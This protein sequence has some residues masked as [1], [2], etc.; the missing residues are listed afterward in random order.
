MPKA[1][2]RIG[3]IA[4]ARTGRV[5][6]IDIGSKSIRLVVYDRLIR[7]PLPVFNEKVMCGLGR[8]LAE[9]GRLDPGGRDAALENLVRFTTLLEG[10]NVDRVDVLATAAVRDAEDGASFVAEVA[11][12]TGLDIQVISGSE[13]ARL[14]GLG[15]L[16]GI[17]RA[18][19]VVGDLGGGSLE[20]VG[21]DQ[22]RISEQATLPLGPFRLMG[23]KGAPTKARPRVAEILAGEPW[24][25]A[26][27]GRPLYA[28]GG[29]WRALA[30]VHMAKRDHPIHVIQ[31]YTV[32]GDDMAELADLIAHQSSLERM[33]GVSKR[34]LEALPYAATVMV[35]LHDL[36]APEVVVFSAGGLR[37]GHLFDLLP[38]DQQADDPLL[39]ACRDIADRI[40][41]F[42]LGDVG[43]M[44][45]WI[46]P[47][48][49]D[50]PP[51][52]R[53]LRQ[54]AALL[55]DIGWAEH[56][57]YRAEHAFL[58]VL[59]LHAGGLSHVER[60]QLAIATYA[61]YGGSPG[62]GP[63]KPAIGLLSEEERTW[64]QRLGLALRLSHTLTGG[65]PEVLSRTTL[66]HDGNAIRLCLP[67]GAET[68][69][70]D[71]VRRRL[72]AVAKTMGAKAG[73]VVEHD[74]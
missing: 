34:R 36:L 53:R 42:G 3:P 4:R 35:A 10:M 62:N 48:F 49:A 70:G 67:S 14:S 24:L 17:P 9:T 30:K 7:A 71:V 21:V 56:P 52:F 58:R 57:D 5:G 61:R 38:A 41:R 28:V 50:E 25:E 2:F 26:Y 45:G 47:L 8:S 43:R 23:W 11:A 39:A 32:P 68:L 59:R 51:G 16:S 74:P 6:V 55:S 29:A 19:G 65:A 18:D 15:V 33:P 13:E 46:D 73:I 27:R 31:E 44:A 66:E 54:A 72:D 22:G 60:A 12:R 64:A 37:E 1:A 63:T 69:G 40:D 20:L